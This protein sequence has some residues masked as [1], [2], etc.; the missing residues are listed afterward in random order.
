MLLAEMV[1]NSR[2][3]KRPRTKEGRPQHPP[4]SLMQRAQDQLPDGPD[5]AGGC[6]SARLLKE[7]YNRESGA[8]NLLHVWLWQ[9]F[10]KKLNTA[11]LHKAK[12][13][14]QRG[15]YRGESE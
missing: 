2:F 5:E 12:A 13:L 9:V 15:A 3:L 14:L 10:M 6:S 1:G 7:L 4:D 11:F 8:Y